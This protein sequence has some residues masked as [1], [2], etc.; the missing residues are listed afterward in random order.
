MAY[1][2]TSNAGRDQFAQPGSQVRDRPLR[3]AQASKARNN[4]LGN[5]EERRMASSNANKTIYGYKAGGKG[6][7]DASTDL[8]GFGSK[9]KQIDRTFGRV[10]GRGD[11]RSDGIMV[12]GKKTKHNA[13]DA[14]GRRI[15]PGYYQP[16]RGDSV[17]HDRT[18]E[19]TRVK[20]NPK[21]KRKR[22]NYLAGDRETD[23][24]YYFKTG[25]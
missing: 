8:D 10:D 12:P 7:A 17:H 6:G 4:A 20:S 13:R 3:A 15:T 16:H 25:Y 2:K 5:A 21:M 24:E 11:G 9:A 23:G 1:G 22:P 14:S 19:K 18:G